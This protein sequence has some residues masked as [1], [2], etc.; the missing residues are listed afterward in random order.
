MRR[1][2]HD[3]PVYWG[4]RNWSP[5]LTE[6]VQKMADDG[7]ERAI[8]FVTSAYSSYSGCRQYRED[9]AA[10][11]SEV[12]EAPSI[13][14]LRVFFNHPGFVEPMIGNV[15]TAFEA[16]PEERRDNAHV[17][18]TAHS[19][20]MSMAE[21]SSYVEQLTETC[22][23]VSAATGEH[24]WELVWQSR[25]GP[26]QIPWLEP[27]VTDHIEKLATEGVG[28][29]VVV[30]VGF[31]SDHLEVLFDLDIEAAGAAARLGVNMVRAESVGSHPTY[32]RMIAELIEERM[33]ANPERPI[34]GTLPPSHDICARD[35]CPAPLR[36]GAEPKL[37]LAEG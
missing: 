7:V 3:L 18:F 35:C 30:P 27:D 29:V 9:L 8:C 26:P 2:G 5:Y 10:A 36:P 23:L 37:A 12:P 15:R 11:V 14:K 16:I 21:T 6:T 25:S 24:P 34:I 20:P 32:V 19:V 13:D 1:R 28:D 4:N 17:V 22:R 33:A 31:V